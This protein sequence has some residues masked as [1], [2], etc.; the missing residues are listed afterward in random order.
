[1][2]NVQGK[3]VLHVRVHAIWI[4]YTHVHSHH[5]KS[6]T[7]YRAIQYTRDSIQKIF[8]NFEPHAP[9]V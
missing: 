4:I 9:M 3:C 7:Q 8:E 5:S 2:Q 1:M 6:T